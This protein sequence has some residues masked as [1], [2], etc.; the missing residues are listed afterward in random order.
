MVFPS[1]WCVASFRCECVDRVLRRHEKTALGRDGRFIS[2]NGRHGVHVAAAGEDR[3]SGVTVETV[4]STVTACAEPPHDHF[5]FPIGG[6][7]HRR[8]ATILAGAPGNGDLRRRRG[9]DLEGRQIAAFAAR[10]IDTA[11]T[12]NDIRSRCSRVRGGAV[13]DL[14]GGYLGAV[15]GLA[16][17]SIALAD[18]AEVRP[19]DQISD[20]VLAER[21]D[22]LRRRCTGHVD[23]DRVRATEIGVTVVERLPIRGSKIVRRLCAEDR[24]WLK[25]E[26]GFAV[27]P[28]CTSEGVARCNEH[29]RFIRRGSAHAP[30]ATGRRLGGVPLGCRW[31]GDGNSDDP[32]VVAAAVTVVSSI[33]NVERAVEKKQRSALVLNGRVERHGS[34]FH[35]RRH[36][37]GPPWAGRSIIEREAEDQM[38]LRLARVG[39][40]H[41]V[42]EHRFGGGIDGGCTGDAELFDVSARQVMPTGWVG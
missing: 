19:I 28:R 33:G 6:G 10:A 35:G 5:G 15:D 24:P 7:H 34:G 37:E 27:S 3:C 17:H 29:G 14:T 18:T 13:D 42:D 39:C 26:N 38:L 9:A 23:Q 11:A 20:A 12:E 30:D 22:E 25:L 32:A 41:G 4:E 16:C 36:V 2:L 40:R 21:D 31:I 1:S 8:S